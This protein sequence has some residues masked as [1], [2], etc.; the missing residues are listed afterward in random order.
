MFSPAR[1]EAI[2]Q[3]SQ[4]STGPKTEE[5]KQRSALNSVKHGFTGQ[6]M[7]LP[8][9]EAEAYKRF[10]EGFLAEIAPKGI[11]ETHLAHLVMNNRWRLTQIAATESALYALG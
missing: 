7:I 9:E 8:A 3:N 1:I 4:A 10:T 5:G 2:R 11:H 6:T